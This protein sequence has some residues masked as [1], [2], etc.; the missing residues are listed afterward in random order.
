MKKD[1]WITASKIIIAVCILLIAAILIYSRVGWFDGDMDAYL[2]EHCQPEGKQ[3]ISA[4]YM[5][6]GGG[7]DGE[8]LI[9]QVQTEDGLEYHIR[10]DVRFQRTL[11]Q[12]GPRYKIKGFTIVDSKDYGLI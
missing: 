4:E 8:F 7:S 12:I 10:I 9:Y 1:S 2:K 11:M 6:T 5:L 3:I